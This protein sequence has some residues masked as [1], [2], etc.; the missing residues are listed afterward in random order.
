MEWGKNQGIDMT[1]MWNR[2]PTQRL[3]LSGK[4]IGIW[5]PIP[6]LYLRLGLRH[7][8]VL[9]F[10]FSFHLIFICYFIFS[11]KQVQATIFFSQVFKFKERK[12]N[13]VSI[14]SLR[15]LKLEAIFKVEFQRNICVVCSREV[16][17]WSLG[18][19]RFK[20]GFLCL[21]CIQK[22]S[23]VEAHEGFFAFVLICVQ[24]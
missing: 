20:K 1:C 13:K 10:W 14:L 9:A 24:G 21:L 4:K 7:P 15:R 19:K 22:K 8:L 2:N 17:Q 16:K 6:I 3:I 11:S 5:P 23:N 18:K 12:F